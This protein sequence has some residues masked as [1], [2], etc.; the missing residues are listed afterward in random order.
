MPKIEEPIAKGGE[1]AKLARSTTDRVNRWAT[2][3]TGLHRSY[4]CYDS[5]CFLPFTAPSVP[6]T[7]RVAHTLHQRPVRFTALRRC[8][9]CQRGLDYL[10]TI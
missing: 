4:E 10:F 6:A 7:A 9:W 2:E 5:V 1:V 8:G 3:P